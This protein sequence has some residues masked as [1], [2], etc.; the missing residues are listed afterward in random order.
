[1]P[2]QSVI[3]RLSA[4]PGSIRWAGRALNA[5]GAEVAASGWDSPSD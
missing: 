2:M 1:T 3:A 4:T 5:D